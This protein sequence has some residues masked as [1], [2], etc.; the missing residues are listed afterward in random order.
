MRQS[1][2]LTR[3]T[4]ITAGQIIIIQSLSLSLS[5][6]SCLSDLCVHFWHCC[7]CCCSCRWCCYQDGAAVVIF[8]LEC[9]PRPFAGM[10]LITAELR[11]FLF[12]NLNLFTWFLC[13]F[14]FKRFFHTYLQIV[15]NLLSNAS[16]YLI[17]NYKFA[18]KFCNFA[19]LAR[20]ALVMRQVTVLLV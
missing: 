16:P 2:Y 19:S 13:Y 20:S 1:G 3:S 9:S 14:S 5:L 4:T 17:Y 18:W 7:C 10:L 15:Y 8:V 6:C 12:L 11:H